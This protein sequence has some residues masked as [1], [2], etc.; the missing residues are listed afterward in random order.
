[1][2]IKNEIV[3]KKQIGTIDGD[4]VFEIR[5]KGGLHLVTAARSN[6]AEILGAGPHRAVA[7][8]IA[9]KKSANLILT[10]LAKS[11]EL[12]EEYIKHV[13]PEYEALTD[14]LRSME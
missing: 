11:S 8:F 13:L 2:D 1:M 4:D 9:K 7:R 10:E 12:Q 6:K 14:Q 3:Y 5:T